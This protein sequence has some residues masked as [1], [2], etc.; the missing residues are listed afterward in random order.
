MNPGVDC[1]PCAIWFINQEAC[2]DC[3]NARKS[4]GLIPRPKSNGT[5]A[6]PQP[7]DYD[8]VSKEVWF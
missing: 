3:E 2:E 1:P 7:F 6:Q 5:E 8:S 4:Y